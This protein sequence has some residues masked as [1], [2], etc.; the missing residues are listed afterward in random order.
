MPRHI[1]VPPEQWRHL[2]RALLRECSYLPDPIARKYMHDHVMLR[3]RDYADKHREYLDKCRKYTEKYHRPPS[4]PPPKALSILR[5]ARLRR[6]AK[7]TLSLLV[8]A[9][10]G[11]PR[12]LERVLLLSYGRIG[13]RRH[14]LLE[15]LLDSEEV[16]SNTDAVAEAVKK[17]RIWDDGWK[18]PRIL[19]ELLKAQNHAAIVAQSNVRNQVKTFEPKIPAE[20]SWGRPVPLCRRR[21]IRRKWYTAALN[22]ALPPIPEDEL[23]LLQGL[24]SGTHSWAPVRRRK[25]PAQ[26]APSQTS[27]LDARFLAEGPK[28]G[29]TF[30]NFTDGRPHKITRRLMERLWDRIHCLIPRFTMN[31]ARKKPTFE[32]PL[33]RY[34]RE[35]ALSVDEQKVPD[36]FGGLDEQGRKPKTEPKEVQP[37]VT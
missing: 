29:L 2:L 34:R 32:F 28:K 3:Y 37:N 12:P 24:V 19:V 16:P 21:N 31:P 18:P 26:P 10:E 17:P 36:L 33:P 23:K 35:A 4:F 13:R 7:Q 14:R 9:N 11:Y 6:A 8:R 20:N 15:A 27:S 5:Q 25:A 30:R 22:S 1:L